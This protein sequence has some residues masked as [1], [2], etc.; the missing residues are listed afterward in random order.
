MNE[1]SIS[2]GEAMYKCRNH[3]MTLIEL[4]ISMAIFGIILMLIFPLVSVF[5]KNVSININ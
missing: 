4:L 5:N 2:K 3:G 1:K